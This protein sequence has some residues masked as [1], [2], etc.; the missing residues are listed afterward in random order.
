VIWL[1][2]AS[3][4]IG[5]ALAY[6]LA[7]RGAFLA[8]SA[9]R[10]EVL[11]SVRSKCTNPD[12]HAVF[13]LDILQPA[14]FAAA[15]ES[16]HSRFGR[17]D[18][19]IHAAGISQ[20][21]TAVD[22]ELK[23]DRH[24]LGLNYLGPVAL[25]KQ[26]LPSMLNRGDGQ[27]VVISSL[28][29]KF[30]LPKRAAYSASKHALHGFFDALRAEVAMD[31]IAVTMVCPGFVRTNAS[32]NALEGDGTPHNKMDAQIAHGL[33]PDVCARRIVRAIERRRREIYICRKEI[34]GLYFSRF[35]PGLFSRYTRF[36]RRK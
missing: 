9:R 8:L 14:S 25:T 29:G 22:T 4:G 16:V 27:I 18:V 21:G 17:I 12:E 2:G 13:P 28:L 24:L 33:S 3:S 1:T 20:R 10:T 6:E 15:L 23:V 26:V 35:A 36:K 31:G 5:E 7:S 30:A 32:F 11:E 34:F 19:L